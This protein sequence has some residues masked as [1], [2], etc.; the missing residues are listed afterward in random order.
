MAFLCIQCGSRENITILEAS[1]TPTAIRHRLRC[2]CG[3]VWKRIN[4]R[5]ESEQQPRDD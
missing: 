5:D 4:I 1:H 3:K 2:R